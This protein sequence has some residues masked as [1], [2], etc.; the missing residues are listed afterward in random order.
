MSDWIERRHIL[1]YDSAVAMRYHGRRRG[2]LDASA[3]LGPAVSI[4]LGG[5]AFATVLSGH[6]TLAALA[7]LAV[8]SVN[9]VNLSF[10]V[11]DRARQHD[12]LFR[13]W[14]ALRAELAGLA[15][16]DDT[17]LRELEAKRA[18]IDADSPW[19]L[20]A[21]SVICENEEKKVRR[22]G[23]LFRVGWLQRVLANYFTLPWW[24]PVEDE[25]NAIT[26]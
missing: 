24:H 19:Q 7:A 6:P 17:K 4:V 23:I 12:A 22:N 8:A 15:D 16:D 21:L 13:Q 26:G 14:G 10:G 20:L 18:V 5:A 2:F 1:E 25:R 11:A 3:R 9:A